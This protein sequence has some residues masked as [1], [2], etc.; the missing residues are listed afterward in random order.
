MKKRMSVLIAVLALVG[1]PMAGWAGV[2]PDTDGDGVVDALD[3]CTL[4][5]NAPPLDCDT[6]GDLFGNACDGD[7]NQSGATDA[8]DFLAPFFLTDFGAGTDSGIGTDMD[9]SGAVDATDF[10]SPYFLD[11]FT[12][13]SPGPSGLAP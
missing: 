13:G 4:V 11:N 9:C 3:N 1:L 5:P 7:F 8:T 10:L 12:L 6:D 2:A